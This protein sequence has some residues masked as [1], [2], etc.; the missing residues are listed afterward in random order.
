MANY[1]VYAGDTWTFNTTLTDAAG[2]PITTLNDA[3][4]SIYTDK[5]TETGASYQLSDAEM[6]LASN[7]LT[8]VVPTT[9]TTAIADGSYFM[10]VKIKDSS[11]VVSTVTYRDRVRVINNSPLYDNY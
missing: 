4:L 10:D 3:W 9:I 1:T 7:V 5:T 8:V 11:N 2:D 6:T